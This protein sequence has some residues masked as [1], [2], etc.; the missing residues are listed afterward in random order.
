MKDF[1]AFCYYYMRG[2][3]FLKFR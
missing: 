1:W 3:S 2:F